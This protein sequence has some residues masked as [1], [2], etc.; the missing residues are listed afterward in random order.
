MIKDMGDTSNVAN[1]A[2]RLGYIVASLGDEEVRRYLAQYD[3][4]PAQIDA[5]KDA[6]LKIVEGFYR[7]RE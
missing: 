2:L 5:A 7:A 6:L 4:T 1:F 3:V